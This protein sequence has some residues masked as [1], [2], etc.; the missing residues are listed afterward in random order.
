MPKLTGVKA[1][2]QR[3]MT[4]APDF[5]EYSANLMSLYR[6]MMLDFQGINHDFSER[7]KILFF[8]LFNSTNQIFTSLSFTLLLSGH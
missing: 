8:T 2:T 5:S 4:S 7:S 3:S 1:V 6:V